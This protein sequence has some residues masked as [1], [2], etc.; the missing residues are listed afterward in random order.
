MEKT[1]KANSHY[2]GCTRPKKAYIV[3]KTEAGK[4]KLKFFPW[5][6]EGSVLPSDYSP[7]KYPSITFTNGVPDYV[8]IPCGRCP[9]CKLK[10]AREWSDRCIAETFYHDE[11][12]F[13]TLT[14]DDVH[15]P[16][17]DRGILT[18][19]KSHMSQFMKN[20][21]QALF[22]K[23]GKRFT[24]LKFFG[25]GEYGSQTHRPHFHLLVFGLPLDDLVRVQFHNGKWLYDSEFLENIWQKGFVRIGY[26]TKK[27][28]NYV[29]RYTYKKAFQNNSLFYQDFEIE[30]E[31][32][33]MSR[34]PGLGKAFFEDHGDFLFENLS[35][36]FGTED[37]GEKI[38]VTKYWKKLLE[39]SDP[40]EYNT[41]KS[42]ALTSMLNKKEILFNNHDKTY[43]EI[44][45][46]IENEVVGRTKIFRERKELNASQY[47]SKKNR[48][49][50]FQE[51][52]NTD[53]E[54]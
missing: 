5:E 32:I 13:L 36:P 35:Y 20:L 10:Y 1:L 4:D 33:N 42:T 54:N 8:E 52:S 23:Y 12:Y 2:N 22:R 24:D 44:L 16:K 48:Q 38:Y 17:N 40:L 31:F 27:S 11:N 26:V 46:D 18:L 51:N 41:Y 9:S 19:R 45:K 28:A 6:Y 53:E 29:A 49:V 21:R 50:L 14:Y 43:L 39:K 47:N 34:R 37:G 30:P 3:G 7:E 15:V 25:C